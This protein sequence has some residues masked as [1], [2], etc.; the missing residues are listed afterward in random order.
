MTR[1]GVSSKTH[2]RFFLEISNKHV[3][4]CA[5]SPVRE[6]MMLAVWLFIAEGFSTARSRVTIYAKKSC[7]VLVSLSF[8]P[9]RKHCILSLQEKLK[10]DNRLAELEESEETLQSNISFLAEEKC[11]VLDELTQLK[12]IREEEEKLRSEAHDE[13][14]SLKAQLEDT[15][16]SKQK[17]EN[18]LATITDSLQTMDAEKK[19]L[20]GQLRSLE[21][22]MS[23]VHDERI[24]LEHELD[25]AKE[26][27]EAANEARIRA[28]QSQVRSQEQ[29]ESLQCMMDQEVAALKFQLSSETMK[30]E[31]ELKVSSILFH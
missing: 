2:F 20:D 13:L 21:E 7:D 27:L 24:G 18:E 6:F 17:L 11:K 5:L 1:C 9:N 16:Q 25:V 28:E 23:S 8:Q 15:A 10:A 12:G 4:H 29:L 19:D 31:T 30:Y 22:K 14:E 3:Q 26:Q